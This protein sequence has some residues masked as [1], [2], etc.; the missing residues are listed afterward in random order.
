MWTYYPEGD[1]TFIWSQEPVLAEVEYIA[2]IMWVKIDD[3]WCKHTQLPGEFEGPIEE[4]TD[5]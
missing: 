4:T 1:E 3:M 2:G 5:A